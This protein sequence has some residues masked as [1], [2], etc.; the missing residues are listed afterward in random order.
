MK[1]KQEERNEKKDEAA[2]EKFSVFGDSTV[3]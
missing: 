1:R 3:F 2:D